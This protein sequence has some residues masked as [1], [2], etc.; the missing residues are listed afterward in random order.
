MDPKLPS[1]HILWPKSNQLHCLRNAAGSCE[2]TAVGSVTQHPA[3]M[4][5]V[6]EDKAENE[7]VLGGADTH[8]LLHP[9]KCN[10]S[11]QAPWYGCVQNASTYP[12]VVTCC[13]MHR[14]LLSHSW[15]EV[16][17]FE[18]YLPFNNKKLILP[19]MLHLIH[20]KKHL[21]VGIVKGNLHRAFC[22][23][24]WTWTPDSQWGRVFTNPTRHKNKTTHRKGTELWT[25][26]Y[27]PSGLCFFSKDTSN[28]PCSFFKFLF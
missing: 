3:E 11:A 21:P 14:I 15:L 12:C 28:C 23:L 1:L 20:A 9:L 18:C 8:L 25:T 6:S 4:A 16:P 22:H 17:L 24:N 13:V 10:T 2:I 26:T 5:E 27:K 19:H 7:Q